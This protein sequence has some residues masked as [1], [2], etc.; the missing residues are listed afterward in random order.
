MKAYYYQP[1]G[2]LWPIFGA[3]SLDDAR[4]FF[5]PDHWSY[6]VTSSNDVYVN[7]NTGSVDFSDNWDSLDG[8]IKVIFDVDS[9]QWIDK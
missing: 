7:P 6:I 2:E 4:F 5:D 3:N 9:E 1:P 8:L